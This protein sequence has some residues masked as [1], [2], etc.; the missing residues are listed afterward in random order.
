MKLRSHLIALVV[1]ALVPV[2][3]FAGAVVTIQ[4]GSIYERAENRLRD[5]ARSLSQATDRELL[6]SIRT[7]EALA[8]SPHLDSGDIEN[9]HEQ[10][11]RVL[12]T[13][14]G[15][16]TILLVTPSGQQIVNLVIPIGLPLPISRSMD[17]INKAAASGRPVVTNLFG[18]TV[19]QKY[20]VGVDVP[21]IRDGIVRYVLAAS[22]SP[23]FLSKLLSQEKLS[24]DWYATVIDG[25]KAIIAATHENDQLLG[26][27]AAPILAADSHDG[28]KVIF[29]GVLH[30]G[31]DAYVSLNRSEISGWT[32]GIAA[33]VSSLDFPVRRSIM[34]L[35]SGGIILVLVGVLLAAAYGGRI[36][37]SMNTLSNS[38]VALGRREIEKIPASS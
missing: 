6:A 34:T 20:L 24:A 32:V 38:A 30:A 18:G 4:S 5:T 3:L 23:S 28:R 21:V 31:T 11:K 8:T 26:K 33:P 10:A 25:N 37:R 7:L 12:K 36:A 22:S 9:F 2:L 19:A 35:G 1:T 27:P 16:E 17:A 29:R 13:Y 15:W 14:Q